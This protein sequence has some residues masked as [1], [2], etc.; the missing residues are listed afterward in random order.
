MCGTDLAY[1]ATVTIGYR[2]RVSCYGMCGIDLAYGATPSLG[3]Q[4]THPLRSV[5]TSSLRRSTAWVHTPLSSYA[6][7][8]QC[9]VLS[10]RMILRACWAMS[11]TELLYAATPSLRDTQY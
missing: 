5:R 3:Y 2:A 10:Y 6:S 7:P 11:G 8:M 9:P 1:G 4:P